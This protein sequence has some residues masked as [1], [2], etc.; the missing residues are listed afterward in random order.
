MKY[1]SVLDVTPTSEEWIPPYVPV[2]NRLVAKHGGKYLART[3]SHEQVEGD[4]KEAG[5]FA[6]LEWPSK[7]AAMAFMN[8]PELVNLPPKFKQ[9]LIKLTLRHQIIQDEVNRMK[10]QLGVMKVLEGKGNYALEP[11]KILQLTLYNIRRR[12]GINKKL[13][14]QHSRA[15]YLSGSRLEELASIKIPTLVI[16]GTDD[17]L[18]LIEHGE[19]YAPLIPN[20]ES[21]FIDGMGHDIPE[22]YIE[23]IHEAM[24]RTFKKV[25]LLY[26]SPSPRDA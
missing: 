16:H 14:D 10:M 2:A 11:K 25:C 13:R 7:E 6:I 23:K 5:L 1:Y 12:D 15:I 20:A 19:K 8:D 17:P 24:F 18:V 3:A 26:T 21:L 4:K 9:D 22:A